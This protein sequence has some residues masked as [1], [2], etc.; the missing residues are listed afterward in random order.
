MNRVVAPE[1]L[2][3]L[4]DDHPDAIQ[5]RADLLKVNWIMGNHAWMLR[6]LK[7]ERKPGERI[8]ELGAGDGALSRKFVENGLC[9]PQDLHAVDLAGQPANW[10]AGASWHRGDLFATKLPECEILV[11]NLF[12]HHFTDRQLASF[13]EQIS[14]QTR[15]ILAAE[16]A[17]YFAHQITGAVFSALTRLNHVTRYDMQV[18]IRAGF[19]GDELP[20]ALGLQ[21]PWCW[22]GWCTMFGANRVVMRR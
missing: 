20:R 12:L 1:I 4:A 10:P 21:P 9:T 8:C 22:R 15:L 5:S 17:R 11:A 7:H 3:T 6:T 16:P 13:R 2:E 19:R 18:S 14:P